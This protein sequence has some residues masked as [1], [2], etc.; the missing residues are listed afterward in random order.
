MYELKDLGSPQHEL[1]VVPGSQWIPRTSMT[2]LANMGRC[3]G[4]MGV[5]KGRA[6]Y[7]RSGLQSEK[8]I[9]ASC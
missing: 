5:F 4:E 9:M 1:R 8:G 7:W 6:L 3:V 2:W